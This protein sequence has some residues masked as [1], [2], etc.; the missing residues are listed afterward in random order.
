MSPKDSILIV[1]DSHIHGGSIGKS[2][3]FFRMLGHFQKLHRDIVFLG[4]IFELWVALGG[5]ED[6][7]H[8]KFLDWCR[9]AKASR[10]LGF[11]EGN[12]EYFVSSER[13]LAFTWTS[14]A[15][16]A[17]DGVLFAHGDLV[18][19]RD[20]NYRLLRI[21]VRNPFTKALM[22]CLSFI[23]PA[24]AEKVRLAL[25]ESNMEHKKWLPIDLLERFCEEQAAKGVKRVVLGHF[26]QSA[27]HVSKSGVEL[28][29][30]PCW[31]DAGMVG[32]FDKASGKLEIRKWRDV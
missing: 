21:L 19:S 1:A 29:I 26:H 16:R 23:G 30:L 24:I 8:L 22:K 14:D 6:E 12:H 31:R 11:V 4:D 13:G 18:N 20:R 5:Y 10:S 3:E 32:V 9:A 15:G 27:S 17:C 2:D 7:L 28:S 25:K